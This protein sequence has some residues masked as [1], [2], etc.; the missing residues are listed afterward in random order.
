MKRIVLILLLFFLIAGVLF[1]LSMR[2]SPSAGMTRQQIEARLKPGRFSPAGSAL[3]YNDRLGIYI[4]RRNFLLATQHVT[5]RLGPD[6]TATNV[7]TRWA[8][9]TKL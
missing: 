2:W 5:I 6:Q 9:R 3:F 4:G 8:W 7:S 1:T